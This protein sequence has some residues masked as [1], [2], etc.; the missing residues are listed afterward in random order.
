MSSENFKDTLRVRPVDR[1]QLLDKLDHVAHESAAP[2]R[3]ANQRLEYRA[4]DIQLSLTHPGG[5]PGRFFVKARNLSSGGLSFIHGGFLHTGTECKLVLV[6]VN[7]GD[8]VVLGKVRSCRYIT[9]NVHEVG[10]QFYEKLDISR[11]VCPTTKVTSSD[12]VPVM[13]NATVQPTPIGLSGDVLVV[14]SNATELKSLAQR[15]DMAGM[16]VVQADC[17]GVAIDQ[18]KRLPIDLVIWADG[19]DIKSVSGHLAT[20]RGAGFKGPVVAVVESG[21]TAPPAAVDPGGVCGV[22]TRPIDAQ[23][24]VKMVGDL[25]VAAGVGP[26]LSDLTPNSNSS[27]L[28]DFFVDQTKTAARELSEALAANDIETARK[29][30]R[31]IKSTAGGYGFPGVAEAARHADSTLDSSAQLADAAK[32]VQYLIAMLKR[33]KGGYAPAKPA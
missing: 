29:T 13:G 5:T 23:A 4:D 2:S 18:L 10:V 11:F 9:G 17:V 14:S 32:Q 21:S 6:P 12:G 1:K 31:T 26:V 15:M 7:G 24:L 25:T 30:C 27:E 3:R 8:I 22:L 33:V 20:I 28:I 16:N 19:G